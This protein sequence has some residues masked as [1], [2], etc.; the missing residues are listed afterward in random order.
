M[1]DAKMFFFL[2]LYVAI[3]FAG[4]VV[5]TPTKYQRIETRLKICER[6]QK[7]STFLHQNAYGELLVEK[8]N[9]CRDDMIKILKDEF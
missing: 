1:T 2:L 5:M 8:L 4:V 6:Y 7:E 3:M 9:E